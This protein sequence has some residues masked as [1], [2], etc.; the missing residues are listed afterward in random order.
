MRDFL[1]QAR[2][3]LSAIAAAERFLIVT[4]QKPDGDA[5]GSATAL[6]GFLEKLHKHARI[7]CLHAPQE[8]FHYLPHL[9]LFTADPNIF[10]DP[11]HESVIVLDSS[12]LAYAGVADIVGALKTPLPPLMN[13]DHHASNTHFGEYR[14]IDASA[15][16]T[17]SILYRLFSLEHRHLI[18]RPIATSL[19]TGL[20]TDTSHFSNPATSE[21]ALTVGAELLKHGAQFR[22]ITAAAWQHNEVATL[23]IWGKAL[24]RLQYHP[25]YR[26]AVTVLTREDFREARV[27]GDPTE[28]I[29]NFLVNLKEA[30]VIL[31][32]KE[33]ADGTIRGSLRT[34]K[35]DLDVS[36]LARVFGGGGHKKAAGFGIQ[37]RLVQT[38]RGWEI[39]EK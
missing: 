25:R 13:I 3:V 32:L 35:D 27:E 14:L 8:R 34:V 9:R 17:T 24:A 29:A 33:Q 28:G 12:D 39:I 18:D 2:R 26:I 30:D 31:L 38:E 36:R 20:L 5:V 22:Q 7:F 23:H 16:S 37:G 10:H 19:L 15:P 6:A 4:H 11:W 21:H 1:F